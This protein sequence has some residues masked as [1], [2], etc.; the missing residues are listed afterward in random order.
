MTNEGCC[1]IGAEY[2][3]SKGDA[4]WENSE[5]EMIALAIQELSKIGVLDPDLFIDG[6]V[7]KVPKAYP[8]YTGTYPQL[9]LIESYLDGISNLYPI[10][11]NGMHKYNNQDH[12]MLTAFRAVELF[13]KPETGH[14][15]E[16]WGINADDEYHE[17]VKK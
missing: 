8:S 2:F 17:E 15:S 5:S 3:C 11:R 6:T 10:G 1:W 16:L 7:V 12:S 9:G 14:K 4:I 13:I